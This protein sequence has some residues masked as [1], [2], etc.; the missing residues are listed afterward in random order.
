VTAVTILTFLTAVLF[1]IALGA[2]IALC[3]IPVASKPARPFGVPAAAVLAVLA[4]LAATA[5][6][7]ATDRAANASARA[8]LAARYHL[9]AAAS[10]VRALRGGL[11][12][13]GGVAQVTFGGARHACALIQDNPVVAVPVTL[14]CDGKTVSPADPGS[15]TVTITPWPLSRRDPG[16]DSV[17]E[18]ARLAVLHE[19]GAL[20][21]EEFAAAKARV[22]AR[23]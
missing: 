17:R 12:G 5:V 11:L 16:S 3:F 2:V 22:L 10:T 13:V 9:G 14:V 1:V 4:V 20:T 7:F 8:E 6:G 18:L 23:L 21:D 15:A 19:G